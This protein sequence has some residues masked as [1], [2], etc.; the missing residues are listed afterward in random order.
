MKNIIIQRSLQ[1]AFK[2][3]ARNVHPL[4]QIYLKPSCW[5]GGKKQHEASRTALF[6]P[7]PHMKGKQVIHPFN[8]SA[9]YSNTSRGKAE[10]EEWMW[11]ESTCLGLDQIAQMEDG[12]IWGDGPL[13]TISHH[14]M[15]L[16]I[17]NW[18]SGGTLTGKALATELLLHLVSN[19]K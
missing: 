4:C 16:R 1:I 9:T 13:P 6:C 11:K 18:S 19:G 5:E 7:S 12:K 3:K 2:M 14:S 8:S 10:K 17:C 15:C